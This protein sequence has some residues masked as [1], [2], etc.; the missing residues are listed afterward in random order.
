[1]NNWEKV[2]LNFSEILQRLENDL[3]SSVG[4]QVECKY[5][6]AKS[7]SEQA[8][9]REALL[10]A[11]DGLMQSRQRD[12][13]KEIEGYVESFDEI[14]SRLEEL[15]TRLNELLSKQEE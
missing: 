14:T 12:G 6:I 3:N 13:D 4:F 2:Q 1:M 5:W 8:K 15:H 10:M 11:R 7:L 9:T